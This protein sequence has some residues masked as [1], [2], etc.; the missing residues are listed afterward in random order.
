[1]Q[2]NR[3]RLTGEITIRNAAEL[4]RRFTDA[5][6]RKAD[7]V[8]DLSTVESCDAA[9]L[10]LICSSRKTATARG[11]RLRIESLSPAIEAAAR[12]IGL[13]LV[14]LTGQEGADDGL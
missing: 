3:I 11:L 12:G 8:A 14:E 9:G 5:L 2:E 13:P 7:L 10:Q 4:R 1:M 6:D